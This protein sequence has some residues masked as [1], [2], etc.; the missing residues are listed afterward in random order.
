MP[1]NVS[2]IQRHV[3]DARPVIR[4]LKSVMEILIKQAP[5]RYSK[6]LIIPYC[7]AHLSAVQLMPR[8][9][10]FDKYILVPHILVIGIRPNMLPPST[11]RRHSDSNR[12]PC[13][14]HALY[15]LAV[16][17][18]HDSLPSR[19]HPPSQYYHPVIPAPFQ[20]MM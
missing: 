12:K 18:L 14:H 13:H 4:R 16:S 9:L 10:F 2:L 8:R 20:P 6:A 7:C 15:L 3:R 11:T 17:H 5:G 19:A 1:R